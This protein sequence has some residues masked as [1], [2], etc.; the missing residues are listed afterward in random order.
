MDQRV[1][2]VGDDFAVEWVQEHIA[3]RPTVSD[4]LEA[5]EDE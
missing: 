5:D 4:A 2:S 1:I 3:S